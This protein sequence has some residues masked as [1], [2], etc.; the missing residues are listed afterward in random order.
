MELV[1]AIVTVSTESVFGTAISILYSHWGESRINYLMVRRFTSTIGSIRSWFD[2]FQNKM[3]VWIYCKTKLLCMENI[4][5]LTIFAILLQPLFHIMKL[6]INDL[7]I[8]CKL[9]ADG[10]IAKILNS[11]NNTGSA[12]SHMFEQEKTTL[13]RSAWWLLTSHYHTSVNATS[14]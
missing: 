9:A 7:D 11:Q 4:W 1:V 12:M 5:D 10:L 13:L 8:V 14:Y 2:W 6:E 3:T